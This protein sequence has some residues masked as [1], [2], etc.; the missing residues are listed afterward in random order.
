MSDTAVTA[1]D[2]ES[3]A[4]LATDATELVPVVADEPA[5]PT[6]GAGA[7]RRWVLVLVVVLLVLGSGVIGGWAG[8]RW[9]GDDGSTATR[10]VLVSSNGTPIGSLDVTAVAD[11]I[12]PSVVTVSA[13]ENDRVAAIGTGVV[14]TA[15]GEI[16]TNA[17]VVDGAASIRVRL[18]GETE[19]RDA[20]LVG[21]DVAND[22]ALLRVEATDLRPVVFADPSSVVVGEQVVAIGYALDLD[23]GATV[24][25]GIV[26]ALDRT[27]STADGALGG[28]VQTDAAISSGNSGGPLVNAAGEVVGIN[29]A[30]ARTDTNQAANNVGFAIPASRVVQ[31]LDV[32]R[33]GGTRKEGFLGVTIEDRVDG[34]AGALIASVADDSPAS[35]AGLRKGDVVVGANGGSVSGQAGLV[36]TIRNTAPGGTLTL[37]V[38][39]D[40]TTVTLTATLVERPAN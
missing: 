21:I 1:V 16:V 11:A 34:G 29:T 20:T 39:R 35:A 3:D 28:L 37:E 31:Q 13:I 23:G 27:L 36:A 32:L 22:L 14:V 40:G 7:N 26:S 19:P 24:T 30:V 33:R 15:D 5:S 6:A 25:S 8:A 12:T 2:P 18:P 17:H 10:P 4:P 38:L 9:F